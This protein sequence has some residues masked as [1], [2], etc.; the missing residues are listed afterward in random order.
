MIGGACESGVIPEQFQDSARRRI[1]GV[2]ARHAASIHFLY[3]L[4]QIWC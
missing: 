1:V 4:D 3:R 2:V